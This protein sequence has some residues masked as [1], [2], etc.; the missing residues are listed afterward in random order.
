[1]RTSPALRQVRHRGSA[2]DH[3]GSDRAVAGTRLA[4][5]RS[6]PEGGRD[7]VGVGRRRKVGKGTSQG[8]PGAQTPASEP[9]PEY[10]QTERCRDREEN[11]NQGKYQCAIPGCQTN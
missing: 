1:P 4:I 6:G 5:R 3:A 7:V 10:S 11:P 8:V 9:K 2:G